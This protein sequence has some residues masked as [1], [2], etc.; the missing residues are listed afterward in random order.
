M[1]YG[2]VSPG[3]D[4]AAFLKIGVGARAI[5]MGDSFSAVADDTSSIYYNPAGLVRIHNPVI[6]TTYHKWLNGILHGV[7]SYINP[8]F[9][10]SAFGLSINYLGIYDIPRYD[11]ETS[12]SPS[13][14]YS[15]YD[16]TFNCGYAFYLTQDISFG[17]NLKG[18][19]QDIDNEKAAGFGIDF[20]Q[21]YTP[22]KGLSLS[23]VVQHIG[24]QMQ[25]Y[26]MK[27]NLPTVYKLG[28]AY[29]LQ[30]YPLLVVCDITKPSDNN[31]KLNIGFECRIKE[32]FTF[33]G[34]ID[35]QLFH[36][37]HGGISIGFGFP[38]GPYNIDYAIVPTKRLGNTHCI[39][40]SMELGKHA[41]SKDDIIKPEIS[42]PDVVDSEEYIENID[43]IYKIHENEIF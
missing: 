18:L 32:V 25:F 16:V 4:G 36:D 28:I 20:G 40:I 22:V 23:C 17:I 42:I 41:E 12:N 7:I 2:G 8:C 6:T 9:K 13:G 24:P 35:T 19:L 3:R 34:G 27:Y 31:W 10:H 26:E 33:R 1:V 38:L 39:S 30:D 37:T 21:L 5:S 29:K 11:N 14:K 43:T 15:A